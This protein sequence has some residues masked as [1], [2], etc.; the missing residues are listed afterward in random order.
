[1][2]S[3][4]KPLVMAFSLCTISVL[5]AAEDFPLKRVPLLTY[6]VDYEASWSPDG[7]HIVLISSRHGGMK[8]HIMEASDARNGSDMRQITSGEAED[9][10][11]RLVARRPE[12]R[13][14]FRAS[15]GLSHLRHEPGWDWR[16]PG[17]ERGRPE[18]PSHVV[19]GWLADSLQYHPFR[20]G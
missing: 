17:N 1:M 12:D 3:I 7:R 5:G 11:P 13:I 20:R 4:L 8:V 16:T 2:N 6:V 15:G 10:S 14:R 19:C 9:D 18:H